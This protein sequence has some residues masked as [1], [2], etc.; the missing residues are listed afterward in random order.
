VSVIFDRAFVAS[1]L[2]HGTEAQDG[3]TLLTGS[4]SRRQPTGDEYL[5]AALIEISYVVGPYAMLSMVADA[6]G[7]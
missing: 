5:P 2:A 1:S 4:R 3:G 6:I 7:A